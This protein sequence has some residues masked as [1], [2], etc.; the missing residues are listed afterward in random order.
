MSAGFADSYLGRL[1]Q[2]IGSRP[3]LMPGTR[4]IVEN[5]AGEVLLI[6]RGDFKLWGWPAGSAELGQTIEQTARLELLEETGLTAH[7]MTPIGFASHPEHDRIEYPHGDVLYAFSMIFHVTEWSGTLRPDG[8]E[9]LEVRFFHPES[10][11]EARMDQVS[12]NL[13][14]LDRYRESGGTFQLI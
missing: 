11:P 5:A 4:I 12:R 10:L 6:K 1:R 8:D 9:S 14:V 7:A 2:V 3:V 13:S